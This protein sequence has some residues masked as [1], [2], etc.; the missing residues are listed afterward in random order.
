MGQFLQ[1]ASMAKFLS[2]WFGSRRTRRLHI[3]FPIP[4]DNWN[5]VYIPPCQISQNAYFQHGVVVRWG[6]RKISDAVYFGPG[7]KVIRSARIG[8]RARIGAYAAVIED[9]PDDCTVAGISVKVVKAPDRNASA[10]G[11]A[12]ISLPAEPE[13]ILG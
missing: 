9:V 11:P 1:H 7:C 13:D 8:H 3:A 6:C 12:R 5:G 10:A 2:F 4:C